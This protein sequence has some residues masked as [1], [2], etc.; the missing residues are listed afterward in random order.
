[1][2]IL[3]P[4]PLSQ[5]NPVQSILQADLPWVYAC[6]TWLVETPKAARAALKAMRLPTPIQDLQI[7]S[8]KHCEQKEVI[9]TLQAASENQ[10][11]GLLSDAG[12]PAV[13]DPGSEVV[14]LAHQMGCP[15]IPL[16]GP[17]SIMLGLMA[18]G[19]NGQNFHFWG[20]PPV[21]DQDRSEWIKNREKE[22]AKANT[23]Q[24][25]IE[26]PFRNQKLF[27]ALVKQLQPSTLLCVATDLTGQQMQ[28]H[29]QTIDNW[30]RKPAQINKLPTLFLWLSGGR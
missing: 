16:V 1:M 20:Y 24:I 27:D 19:L 22:S 7:I 17:S 9:E 10:P 29:T 23:T 2:L 6:K 15:V 14:L 18:S 13:A 28:V 21:Q 3:T 4:T 5:T 30:R 12:C 26:T 11:V 8:I 25:V